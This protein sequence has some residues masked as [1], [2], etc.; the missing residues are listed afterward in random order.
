MSSLKDLILEE[1]GGKISSKKVYGGLGVILSFIAFVLDGLGFYTVNDN[2]FNSML[3]FS[4]SML[5][6][7][8]A[9]H[10][11]KHAPKI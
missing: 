6:L 10:F 7:S 2:L 9:K 5:G 8:I 1:K 3:I 4:G 11:S